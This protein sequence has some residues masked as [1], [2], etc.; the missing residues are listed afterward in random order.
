MTK[1]L[2]KKAG[3]TNYCLDTYCTGTLRRISIKVSTMFF[4]VV[5]NL[6]KHEIFG[7]RVFM[8]YKPV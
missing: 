1:P 8:Q 5:G 3:L 7:S 6:P 4:S 2:K